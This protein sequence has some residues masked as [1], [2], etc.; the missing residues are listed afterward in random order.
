MSVLHRK[1]PWAND[2]LLL[3]ICWALTGC[4]CNVSWTGSSVDERM[5][6]SHRGKG[7]TASSH[8]CQLPRFR[9]MEGQ[10]PLHGPKTLVGERRIFLAAAEL[11]LD[12]GFPGSKMR[13][14]SLFI[15]A[16]L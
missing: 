15:L 3:V 7:R 6:E 8:K 4:V 5:H 2:F 16:K 14:G 10:Y 13:S 1:A 9:D 12:A 11:T